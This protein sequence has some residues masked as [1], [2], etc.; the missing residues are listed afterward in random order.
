MT[1]NLQT[2]LQTMSTG[3]LSTVALLDAANRAVFVLIQPLGH[4]YELRQLQAE[5]CQ[6][7]AKGLI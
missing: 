3:V 1:F 7:G 4:S 2:K 6:S 5:A